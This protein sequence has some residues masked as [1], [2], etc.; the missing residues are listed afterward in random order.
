MQAVDESREK[1]AEFL[2]CKTNEVIFTSGATESD[3]IVIQGLVQ[4]GEH[5]ITS[6][7]EHPAILEPCREMQKKGIE[8][9]YLGV[10]K[11]KKFS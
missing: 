9:T 8:V 4:T 3:N 7:I 2:N 1:I 11:K 5:I 6:K 10:D